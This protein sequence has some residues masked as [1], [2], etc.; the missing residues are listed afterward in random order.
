LLHR[1]KLSVRASKQTFAAHCTNVRWT[2]RAFD[3]LHQWPVLS[4]NILKQW[5]PDERH[6]RREIVSS[7]ALLAEPYRFVWHDSN[8]STEVNN[9]PENDTFRQECLRAFG[10]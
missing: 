9:D 2:K 7:H 5:F 10:S 3:D 8:Q 6:A 1:V 4:V